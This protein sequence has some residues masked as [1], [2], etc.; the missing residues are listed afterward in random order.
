MTYMVRNEL[1]TRGATLCSFATLRQSLSKVLTR[2]HP[3]AGRLSDENDFTVDC[4]D[5]G[6]LFVEAKIQANL[7]EVITEPSMD[8]LKQ[9]L[10]LGPTETNVLLA[11]QL[12]VFDCGKLGD[13]ASLVNFMHS[14]AAVTF[15]GRRCSFG[16][17]FKPSTDRISK[18]EKIV[19]KR[20]VFDKEKLAK[21]KS[22]VPESQVTDPTRVEAV[23]AYFWRHF[24]DVAKAQNPN[25]KMAVVAT[26]VVN[27]R[28]RMDQSL[29]D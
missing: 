18:E 7:A 22:S 6:A 5:S 12:N 27:L 13:G 4:N 20:V 29:P 25:K 17:D 28:P 21:L 23:S 1:C 10:P 24:M 9:F 16:F 26:H 14:W 15:H 11:I 8:E 3:L 19:S 2:F